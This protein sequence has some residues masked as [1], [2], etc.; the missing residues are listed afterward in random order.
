MG[1]SLCPQLNRGVCVPPGGISEV[2]VYG[3]KISLTATAPKSPNTDE[4]SNY[5]NIYCEDNHECD[6]LSS[7]LSS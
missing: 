6:N 4:D 5:H 2:V 7:D 3:G 1:H